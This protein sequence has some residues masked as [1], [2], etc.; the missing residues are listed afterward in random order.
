MDAMT[1]VRGSTALWLSHLIYEPQ[2]SPP[3][4]QRRL[5]SL[6]PTRSLGPRNHVHTSCHIHPFTCDA[7][8]DVSPNRPLGG[9]LARY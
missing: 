4:L 2:P 5:F 7:P 6:A 9:R 3:N 1:V 8:Q